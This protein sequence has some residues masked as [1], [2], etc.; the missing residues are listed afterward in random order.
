MLDLSHQ[1]FS[2][3]NTYPTD[4]KFSISAFKTI[5]KNT[6]RVSRLDFGSHL[7]THLDF[8][9]HIIDNGNESHNFLTSKFIGTAIKFDY[10]DLEN[11]Y[12]KLSNI[13]FEF[14]IINFNW[15]QK[16]PNDEFFF[17]ERPLISEDLIHFLI[18]KKIKGFCC[19]L[20]NVDQN[21]S[22]NKNIH[23]LLLNNDILIY[24]SL[25]NL[26][27]IESY[28]SY[29]FSGV[30]LNIRNLDGFPVRP[31]LLNYEDIQITK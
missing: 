29:F 13:N 19:D 25:N 18:K 8:P 7:G 20:P 6:T 17:D 22:K 5:K 11:S 9:A 30:P 15:F 21:K 10:E 14:I 24:E 12:T 28:K 26:N 2:G 4:P 31:Y 27:L 1:L 16:F 3:I 23:N